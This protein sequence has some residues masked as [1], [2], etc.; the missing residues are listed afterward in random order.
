M[1]TTTSPARPHDD[2]AEGPPEQGRLQ[3]LPLLVMMSTSFVLVTAE[4]LPSGV[5]S[6]MA[7]DL[8]VSPGTAAQTITVTAIVGFLVAPTIGLMAPRV[9]RRRLLATLALIAAASSLIVAVAPT[10][11]LML[12]GRVLL[13]GALSGFWAM[14][15]AVAMRLSTPGTLGRAVMI[16]TMGTSLATVAGVPLGVLVA[17]HIGWRAVFG[18]IAVI[19][20]LV[21][22]ALMTTLPR[23]PATAAASLASLRQTIRRPGIAPGLI[24]HVLTVL[25]HMLAFAFIRLA[26]ERLDGVTPATITLLLSLFGV[27]GL[28]GGVGIGLLVDRHLAVL[29]FAV[30]LTTA[31]AVLGI[32]L[33]PPSV[34]GIGVLVTLWGGAFGGW[35][36]VV[37][38]WT[39][40]QVPD[41]PE[42]GGGLIVA[43]FQLAITLGAALGGLLVDG[44]GVVA[45]YLVG[46]ALLLVGGVVFGRAGARSGD[47]TGPRAAADL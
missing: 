18:G 3:L 43:G 41:S 12:L 20:L 11:W 1:T 23:V 30:P 29:R 33:L 27:G 13:G 36:I 9:D 32:A 22:V 47:L 17:A 7:A 21:A 16:V 40:R 34:V 42:A 8:Q 19:T 14:S 46:G 28:V 38:A 31:V 25:G 24:G 39:S 26:V 6:P 10:M 5:L 35:L 45:A 2:R 15:L 37:N 4:F 44:P